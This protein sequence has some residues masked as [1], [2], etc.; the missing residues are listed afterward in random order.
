MKIVC[1]NTQNANVI[2]YLNNFRQYTYW[3]QLEIIINVCEVLLHHW[4]RSINVNTNTTTTT[5]YE[6]LDQRILSS[7]LGHPGDKS[8]TL[9]CQ[10]VLVAGTPVTLSPC[11]CFTYN[12]SMF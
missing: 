5:K 11:N 10:A 8:H 12:C 9:I 1:H 2:K 6:N 3:L 7:G 4:N